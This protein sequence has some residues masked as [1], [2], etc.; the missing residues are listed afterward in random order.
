MNMDMV[1]V[2]DMKETYELKWGKT[3]LTDIFC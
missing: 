2:R 3:P 1:G